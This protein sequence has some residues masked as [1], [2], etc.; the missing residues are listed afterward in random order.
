MI[1]RSSDVTPPLPVE[2]ISV[3]MLGQM[4]MDTTELGLIDAIHGDPRSDA[5]RLRYAQWLE[6]NG[7]PEYAEFIRIQCAKPRVVVLKAKGKPAALPDCTPACAEKGRRLLDLFPSVM[8]SERF[9][10][11]HQM[12]KPPPL[13]RGLGYLPILDRDAIR[14][15]PPPLVRLSLS[16]SV[17]GR[18]LEQLLPVPIMAR[19]DHLTLALPV[20]EMPWDGYEDQLLALLEWPHL[21]RLEG[22]SL[23]GAP[24]EAAERL[25]RRVPVAWVG[26]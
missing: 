18:L 2:R 20:P 1:W 15:D 9:A 10:F 19:V 6:G 17:C 16:V 11:W 7:E 21:K 23:M 5:P 25:A 8:A 3:R 22:V 26:R 24:C 14:F 4:P 13:F 12:E